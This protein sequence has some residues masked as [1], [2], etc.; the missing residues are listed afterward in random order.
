VTSKDDIKG[1]VSLKFLRPWLLCFFSWTVTG[2]GSWASKNSDKCSR[3]WNSGKSHSCRNPGATHIMTNS[4]GSSLGS[5]P[6]ISQKCKM[7]DI[8]KGVA[9]TLQPAKKIYNKNSAVYWA[10]AKSI[11]IPEIFLLVF[12]VVQANYLTQI[13]DSFWSTFNSPWCSN[14]QSLMHWT[15]YRSLGRVKVCGLVETLNS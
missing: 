5:N 1:L 9:N 6:D 4:D 2:T 13:R 3:R 7:G 11:K 15:H 8:S 14:F 10:P 12:F